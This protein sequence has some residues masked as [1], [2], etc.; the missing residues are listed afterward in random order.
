MVSC[1]VVVTE[2]AEVGVIAEAIAGASLAAFDLEFLTADRLI[3]TLCVVQVSWSS[4]PLDAPVED[5]VATLPE[6]RVID[7][8]AV[9][10]RVVFEALA[11]H[12]NTVVHAARQ[13]LGIVGRLGIAMP[14]V[15]DTQVMAAFAGIGDQVG[16]GALTSELLGVTLAKEH[17]WTDWARR[18][19]SEAQL[20]YA[21]ADVLHL[22]AI[23]RMLV[24]KLGERL[25]WARA[26][27]RE[28]AS[29]ALAAATLAPEDAWRSLGGLRGL[30]PLALAIVRDL[31]AWRLRVA[32]E[33]D[34]P[35]G[36]VLPE[37]LILDLAKGRPS[38]PDV[39]RSFKGLPQPARQRAHELVERITAA[40]PLAEATRPA[41]RAPSA[42]AQRW[43]ELLLAIVQ[44]AS[45]RSGVSARLLA[46]RGDAEEAARRIDEH[47]LEAARDLPAFS[48]WRRD[49]IGVLWEGW[50]TG[51]LGIAGSLDSPSG[52]A[53]EASAQDQP[54]QK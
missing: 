19:L 4:D 41:A 14:N 7:A 8:L 16:L 18:P 26:E 11:A 43:A 52:I 30:D 49:V 34:K 31:A 51:K 9:D 37:K 6:V 45:E 54:T 32:T 47:G 35:L 2:P 17:Q 29:D 23:Y 48:T 21:R 1:G 39:L 3:P 40:S 12:P 25:P 28:I 46:T 50:L 5:F 36:W 10:V 15:I 20:A 44:L 53:L 24:A 13:D 38:D 33:L 22:P 42:R 27:S